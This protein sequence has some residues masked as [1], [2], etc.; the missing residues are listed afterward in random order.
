MPL[1]L[2]HY[3]DRMIFSATK[4]MPIWDKIIINF[5]HQEWSQ[6]QPVELEFNRGDAFSFTERSA[7][8]VVGLNGSGKTT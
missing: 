1:L 7:T 5:C 4:D 2:D 8:I 6:Q 3:G